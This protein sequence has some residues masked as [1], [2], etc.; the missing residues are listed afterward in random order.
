[1]PFA[2]TPEPENFFS[3]ELTRKAIFF[4][5]ALNV[6]VAVGVGRGGAVLLDVEAVGLSYVPSQVRHLFTISTFKIEFCA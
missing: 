2:E 1:M 6:H 5:V 4:N 3:L